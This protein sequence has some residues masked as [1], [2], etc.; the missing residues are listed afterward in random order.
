MNQYIKRLLQITTCMVMITSLVPAQERLKRN[1][2]SFKVKKETSGVLMRRDKEQLKVEFVNPEVVRVQY[3]P[4]GELKDNATDMCVPRKESIVSFKFVD[5]GNTLALQSAKLKVEINKLTGAIHYLS[6]GGKSLLK[7][8]A[9]QPRVTEAIAIEQTAYDDSKNK[10]EKTAN[11]DLIVSEVASKKVVGP[12]WKARHQFKW[13]E[14]EALYGLGSH[15]EDYMN[16]RGTMQYL[17][18]HNLKKSVPVLMS[19]RGYGLLFDVGSTMIFHDD[20]AG[21]FMEMNAVN[22]MDYYFMYGPEFD[23]IVSHYRGLTGKI[24]LMPKYIF[25]YIQSKER[26]ANPRDLD[27]VVTRF[28]TEKIPLDVIV[29]DWNYWKNGW[30]GHKKFD[31]Q[32]YPDPAGMISKIHQ[33][34]ARFMLSIWPSVSAN[35]A[36]EM[37]KKGYVLGRGIYD[38]YKPDSRKM[39]WTQYVNKNLF[40]NGVDAWWCDS[41]EP[42]DGDWNEKYN[43]IA[44]NPLARFEVNSKSLNDLLSPL[45]ANTFSLHHSQGIYENQRGMTNEKRVVNL[46]RSGF[47][48]LQRYG[49]FVWNGDTKATWADFAQQIPSGLNYMATGLPYWT[50]DAGAFFVKSKSQWFSKGAFDN[51]TVDLG[52]REFYVRNLQFC[53]WLPMFRSHGTDCPREPWQF[54][55]PGEPFYESIIKQINLRYRLLPYTYSIAAKVAFEDFTMTRPLIFDFRNDP[56]V[57]DLKDQFMF[58]PAFMA[59]PVTKPMYYEPNST[60]LVDISKTRPV[61]L[62]KNADWIDFYTGKNY[63]GGSRISADAPI[64]HIPVFVRAGAIVP[65]GPVQ[66]YSS[67]KPNAPWEI[68]I[69]P[70]ADGMFTIYEDEGDNYNYEEGKS[71][72]I[73]LQWD[74]K[75]KTLT[76][77]DRKGSFDNMVPERDFRVIVVSEGKGVGVDESSNVDKTVRYAGQKLKVML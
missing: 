73:S 68:R 47:A 2:S 4:A 56:N 69:Y 15:Q 75:T 55:N 49:T 9:S 36:A 46:T 58:G 22:E 70:G 32:V 64:D 65:M 10:V 54:G 20:N 23:R 8:N 34:N 17:Y 63:P 51:G 37:G 6:L 16:L 38:A 45:R 28:R 74:N 48:G 50:I 25:G 1:V 14:G 21:S 66:Q 7:E 27:S 41:S 60:E 44:S 76:I 72:R 67:E 30:W 11:G 24:Q 40:S 5:K 3:V 35:E 61:Y 31:E 18:Q 33:Q 42:I 59:C 19:S 71:A 62:P 39:Y 57:Y 29:Q 12:A 52:Y 77:G 26:Y 53:Q 43:S 13:Q